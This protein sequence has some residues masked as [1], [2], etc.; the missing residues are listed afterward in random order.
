MYIDAE[1]K[2]V[3]VISLFEIV[4]FTVSVTQKE[5]PHF[6]Q[7]NN[8]NNVVRIDAMLSIPKVQH[9]CQF[10]TL[11]CNFSTYRVFDSKKRIDSS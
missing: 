2:N 4:I 1:S 6:I 11:D 7:I 3:Q 5:T 9:K 8:N 10:M